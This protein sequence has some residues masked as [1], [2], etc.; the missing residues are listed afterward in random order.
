[1][2]QQASF[3]NAQKQ[4]ER[5][6]GHL[7][8]IQNEEMFHFLQNQM[9]VNKK[10]WI[11]LVLSE[12]KSNQRRDAP[13]VS[14]L[15]GLE[16]IQSDVTSGQEPDLS[17]KCDY[18]SWKNGHQLWG[19][20][21]CSRKFSSICEFGSII[22]EQSPI[23]QKRHKD[24]EQEENI[25][26]SSQTERNFP[27]E[28]IANTIYPSPS[29]S[30]KFYPARPSPASNS[31]QTVS[32]FS[33]SR[34]FPTG[35]TIREQSPYKLTEKAMLYFYC[36]LR[37]V[38][39][40]IKVEEV[41]AFLDR[42][43][44]T[45]SNLTLTVQVKASEV[46]LFLSMQLLHLQDKAHNSSEKVNLVASSLFHTV[47]QMLEAMQSEPAATTNTRD[48]M[49]K[50]TS[51][52]MQSLE[53]IQDVLLATIKE[54]DKPV[55]MQGLKLSMY[56]SRNR[57]VDLPSN[58]V[59]TPEPGRVSFT[60]PSQNAIKHIID[61]D[62]SIQIKLVGFE[63]NPFLSIGG[64]QLTG[65][66]GSLSL[67]NSNN[68]EVAVYNLSEN[69]EINLSRNNVTK[70]FKSFK[71]PMS[72]ELNVTSDEDTVVINIKP[73][74]HYPLQLFLGFQYRPTETKFQLQTVLPILDDNGDPMYTWILT[75]GML[76]HGVGVYYV[77]ITSP[78]TSQAEVINY[79]VNV[80]T[81]QCLFWGGQNWSTDQCQVG[82]KTT[83]DHSHCLCNHL[84]FFGTTF[85]VMPNALDL[86]QI[87]ELFTQ[88]SQN[89]VVVSLVASIFGV[90]IIV[91][92]W[93]RIKD[94]SDLRKVKVTVLQDNDLLAQY[95][96]LIRVH[97]GFRRG[98]ATTAKVVIL[99]MGSEGQSDPHL[100]TDPEKPVLERG[101]VDEFLLTTFFSLG[102]L[103]SIRLWHDNSGSSPSWYVNHVTVVDIKAGQQW[104][105][106]CNSWL[107]I[108]IGENILDKVFHVASDVELK[109]F[110]NLF[111]M[112]I[113]E[114]LTDQHIWFSV[115]ERPARSPFTRVQRVSC[116][117]SL[118]LGSMLTNIMFWGTSPNE[119]L[120]YTTLGEFSLF[121]RELMIGV[122]SAFIMFPINLGIVQ[123]F[124]SLHPSPSETNALKYKSTQSSLSTSSNAGSLTPESL[125]QDIRQIINLI[126]RTLEDGVPA[127]E[128]EV[129][130]AGDINQLLVLLANVLQMSVEQQKMD[131]NENTTEG[132][133][134]TGLKKQSPK[135]QLHCLCTLLEQVKKNLNQMGMNK[136]KNPYS[137]IHAVDQE[138][139]IK[140]HCIKLFCD[141]S[142]TAASEGL[143]W[144]SAH[145]DRQEDR[146]RQRRF[147]G[148]PWWF[149]YIAWF[150]VVVTS[151]TS[152]FFT[153]LYGL[154]Y[155]KV[156]SIKWLISM[157]TS[158][159]Q[160]VFILQP[161]KALC[162]AAFI[163]LFVRKVDHHGD[164][165]TFHLT[166]RIDTNVLSSE[167]NSKIYH[168]LPV[169]SVEHMKEMKR[170]EKKMYARIQEILVHLVFI[171]LLL[172]IAYGEQN[173]NSFHLNRIINQTFSPSFNNIQSMDDFYIWANNL[174]LPKLY[175]SYKGFITDGYSK[176]LGSPRIQQLRVKKHDCPALKMLKS[177]VKKCEV[178]YSFDEEDMSNYG[179]QWTSNITAQASNL[180]YVWQYQ[181]KLQEYP[182]WR[183]LA[184][185]RGS[186][187]VADLTT[188][189]E[190]ASR[191]VKYL[192][193]NNWIDSYTRAIFIEFTVY[194]ANVNL[195]CVVILT[196]E[197]NGIGA[198]ITSIYL[199]SIQLVHNR[200]IT[201]LFSAVK[202][203]FMLFVIYYMVVQ[204]K[205][206]KKQNWKYFMEKANLMEMS[207]ILCSWSGF[208]L[209]LKRLL[210][211]SATLSNYLKNPQSYVSFHGL[212]IINTAFNYIVSVLVVLNSLKLWCM[213]H[214]NPKLYLLTSAMQ[215]AWKELKGLFLIMGL[216]LVAY[217]SVSYV[218]LGPYLP[219]YA[220]FFKAVL[221]MLSLQL[222]Y[223]NYDEVMELYPIA[224]VIIVTTSTICMT[225]LVL[226]LILTLL[227]VTFTV[228]RHSPTPSEDQEVIDLL[229]EKLYGLFGTRSNGKSSHREKQTSEF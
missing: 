67:L 224:G 69:F 54:G 88:T 154:T 90:Y 223:F 62:S 184:L 205:L 181:S 177:I 59:S 24:N 76:T 96:Y 13:V 189:I 174:L 7:A 136:F 74:E 145:P 213:L 1:M 12:I 25:R 118:L 188:E 122:E 221:A 72:V 4:C 77:M 111:F 82:L 218:M 66:V 79:T 162:T 3:E 51:N 98:A 84:T 19:T 44:K 58:T 164:E 45:S 167:R 192:A 17:P 211:E 80:F 157:A 22:R 109:R 130:N 102:N 27:S 2:E 115:I 26:P 50:M 217:S 94:R 120:Q 99:L 5:E 41:S 194:N 190:N 16:Q 228:E 180:S 105:F 86:T 21:R 43:M 178:P 83:P 227:L 142:T 207:I 197:T 146:I 124:R 106:I 143:N 158:L 39:D 65:N 220:T 18:I 15:D 163:A 29:F 121:M 123:I 113:A 114:S 125:L 206:L 28:S 11:G 108:D 63:F 85:F 110:Q 168:P 70:V 204:G 151:A 56:L 225:F 200:E 182:F 31:I 216:L 137:Q 170:K 139:E 193:E 148:L 42:L 171:S 226:N 159:F 196:L 201:I 89:P 191:I 183:N 155:G 144:P 49:M 73:Q 179:E 10:W 46:L 104:H 126:S 53:K 91:V 215:R 176:L 149:V 97:T 6:G 34:P 61:A 152:A 147:N 212:A 165:Q 199:E 229:L 132:N 209:F 187:Y 185:Y 9:S 8:I 141:R 172:T 129:N 78:T 103:Q 64:K 55:T 116:C 140:S 166:T 133:P 195:F 81:T 95:C 71:N 33:S 40:L 208:A 150:L 210:L 135:L 75:P 119:S 52:L 60:F 47:D 107:A 93:A 222:G 186:G 32:H 203:A 202:I 156:Q 14:C 131:E 117:F 138:V 35:S 112:K 160:S 169:Q 23:K 20:T 161:V 36:I 153:M 173:L 87:P 38:D 30:K 128:E 57:S 48:M 198:F 92:V 219:L 175:G 100:L 101:G 134:T 214:L 37:S 127:L 68:S